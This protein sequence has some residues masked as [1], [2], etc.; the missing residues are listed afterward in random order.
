MSEAKGMQRKISNMIQS[1]VVFPF[2]RP[3]GSKNAPR[4]R[5]LTPNQRVG[6]KRTC[7]LSAGRDASLHHNQGI[8]SRMI[9]ARLLTHHLLRQLDFFRGSPTLK[10]CLRPRGPSPSAARYC[11]LTV[12]GYI[13][14]D[15][16]RVLSW[17]LLSH[18]V[19]DG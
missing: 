12:D 2:S 3:S 13:C 11:L 1:T 7:P 9:R 18:A 10:H 5:Q 15:E 4:I 14:L 17:L 19:D 16:H 8:H 6:S